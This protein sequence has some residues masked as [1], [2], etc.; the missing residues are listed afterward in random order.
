[1][2]EGGRE[3]Q[4][5]SLVFFILYATRASELA[6]LGCDHTAQTKR[7]ITQKL[8]VHRGN[9]IQYNK[10]NRAQDK[11]SWAILY[12]AQYSCSPEWCPGSE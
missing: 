12:Q 9:M 2:G 1:M 5:R 3:R 6:W 8:H 10:A 7:N 4:Y 11:H